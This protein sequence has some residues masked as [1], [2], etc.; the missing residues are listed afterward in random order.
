MTEEQKKNVKLKAVDPANTNAGDDASGSKDGKNQ[1]STIEFPYNDLD[2]AIEIAKAISTNAGSECSPDQLAGFL[3]VSLS[4]PIRTRFS[5]AAMYG[6]VD[7]ERGSIKLTDLG[8]RI[9][10]E[11]TQAGARAEAFLKVPLF[12]AIF[13]KYKGYALPGAKGLEGE[14]EKLGVSSKQ[15]D[16][17]RQTF[18]RSARQG[19]FFAHGEDRL[20]RPAGPG[21]KPIAPPAAGAATIKKDEQPG[22]GGGGGGNG[23]GPDDP[24]IQAMI[25][26]LPNK[27]PWPKAERETWMKMLGMAFD[28]AYGPAGDDGAVN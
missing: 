11:K 6:L 7:S 12:N 23:N 2:N 24:L 27:G 5:N 14:I 1:R 15:K 26:K 19:G 10:D 3:K 25:Q 16:K 21:T 18:M 20:V 9:V 17:A 4:G 28:I 8:H 22:G 13:E